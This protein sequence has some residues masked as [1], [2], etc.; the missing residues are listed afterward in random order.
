MSG[1]TRIRSVDAAQTFTV[2]AG[3][4]IRG[5]QLVEATASGVQPASAGSLAVLGVANK[6]AFGAGA[7]TPD[8]TADGGQPLVDLSGPY[9]DLSVAEKGEFKVT[10]AAGTNVAF[11]DQ[12][13]AAANGTVTKWVAGTD[14]AHLIVGSCRVQG[15]VTGGTVAPARITGNV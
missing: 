14:G 9:S 10:Y 12:L 4:T 15:G 5:G 8:T 11:G 6:D 7:I 1:V 13:K 3:V 2:K